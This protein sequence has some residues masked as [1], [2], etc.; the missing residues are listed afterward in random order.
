[1]QSKLLIVLVAGAL[2]SGLQLPPTAGAASARPA[3]PAPAPAAPV[4]PNPAPAPPP[5][6]TPVAPP[7]TPA[8]T[9]PAPAPT[10]LPLTTLG[11]HWPGDA[12]R[13]TIPLTRAGDLLLAPVRINGHDAGPFLIDTAFATTTLDKDAVRMLGLPTIAPAPL[14]LGEQPSGD[15]V[16][17]A[18]LSVGPAAGPTPAAP[19]Y[20]SPGPTIALAADLRPILAQYN[21]K[22]SGIIGNDLLKTQPVTIDTRAAT[23]TFYDPAR[24]ASAFP[25]AAAAAPGSAGGPSTAPAD[26]SASFEGKLHVHTSGGFPTVPGT[27]RGH[28]GWFMIQ[29]AAPGGLTLY[30]P[31]LSMNRDITE[32]YHPIPGGGASVGAD[33]LVQASDAGPFDSVELLGRPPTRMFAAFTLPGRPATVGFE[34]TCAGSIGAA[35]L[36]DTRITLDYAG[37]RYW[38]T[39]LPPETAE[40]MLTRLGDPAAKDLAGEGALMRAVAAARADV[41]KALLARN[42]DPNADN[43]SDVTP[44]M[45]AAREGREEIV[46]MLLAKGAKPDTKAAVGATTALLDACS[47]GN[48]GIVQALLAAKADAKLADLQGSTPLHRAAEAGSLPCVQALLAAG[49][50]VNARNKEKVSVLM[51][52]AIAGDNSVIAALLKAGADPNSTGPN[53]WTPLI[54]AAAAGSP[55]ETLTALLDGGAKPNFPDDGGRTALMM[56]AQRGDERAAR[57]LIS[58]GADPNAKNVTGRTVRDF[59]ADAPQTD[60]LRILPL[61]PVSR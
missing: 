8:P 13:V 46:A 24:F 58:R 10:T 12:D 59:A 32:G 37:G 17:V 9:P 4:R 22:I 42:A 49:A 31:F 43:A 50:D 5:K 2:W 55:I 19:V 54:L 11:L 41:V 14:H 6:P 38:V 47:V 36:R 25:P 60:V 35:L 34:V 33:P 53:G 29:T 7:P 18:E 27:V 51:A 56:A 21:L 3:A 40:Q 26:A 15:Y 61:A 1:M 45:L 16:E 20:A 44:L 39:P 48:A 52:A 28:E 57:L 23:L 30:G